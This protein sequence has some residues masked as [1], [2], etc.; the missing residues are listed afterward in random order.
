MLDKAEQTD[1]L[2]VCTSDISGQLRGKAIPRKAIAA[3]AEIG[4]G[5][6]PTNAFI[7][8]FGQIAPSPWGALGDLILRPDLSTEVNLNNQSA[9]V[10]ESFVLG[11]VL[12]LDGSAWDCCLRGQLRRALAQLES[13]HGLRLLVAFEHEFY[14][15][16]AETQA[17]LGYALR[18]YRRLGDF[19]NKLMS[20]LDQAGLG[21]DTFMPEFGPGQCEVTIDPALAMRAA[22]E[23]V[24]LR[25]LVRATA[26][27]CGARA[28]FTPI[29]EPD[30]VGNGLHIHFSF[31]D[32]E[33]NPVSYDPAK[34]LEIS[35]A[36]GA[37]I[38]GILKHLPD[39]IA[40]SAASVPSYTRLQ[41]H[42]WSAAF[43]NLGKQDRESAV[44]IC[45]VFG[46]NEDN[47]AKKFHFEFRAADSVSS[48]YLVLASM[49]NAGLSGLDKQLA[50]PAEGSGDLSALD[51]NELKQRGYS[52][53]SQS[54]SEALDK[55]QSS[56]WAKAY[57]GETFI[58]AYLAHKRC[59]A[60]V[61]SDK[62]DLEIC[63]AYLR[64][65]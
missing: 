20:V 7:T 9:G 32:L 1:L 38:A 65:Y 49:V 56:E 63:A 36:A 48:P 55:L 52:R 34:P 44:R 61:M 45:P 8:S 51:S 53:L 31:Q 33:G 64:A 21:I 28:S 46:V 42:R 47:I 13:A 4:V 12:H 10:N 54:L 24:I 19:P 39:S 30:G 25:E 57:F 59:E 40:F 3:R 6:T 60:R 41:P 62:E 37:F 27:G 22:D 43:N 18:A 50:T 15:T 11:D 35:Q 26:R 23:A 16:G 17:G 2:M 58:E 14:Y 5:W 29:V